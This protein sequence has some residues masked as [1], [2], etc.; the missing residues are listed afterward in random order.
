MRQVV[1]IPERKLNRAFGF[2]VKG[3]HIVFH[4][5]PHRGNDDFLINFFESLRRILGLEH[6][7]SAEEER[8]SENGCFHDDA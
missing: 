2:N 4:L 1:R 7:Q 3:G 8:Q 6:G 5:E